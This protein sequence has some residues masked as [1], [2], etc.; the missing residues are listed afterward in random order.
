[1]PDG[2]GLTRNRGFPKKRLEKKER[3]YF[4]DFFIETCR[5]ELTHWI[6][7]LF[8]PLFFFW[9]K[10]PVGWIMVFYAIAENLPLIAVQRYNR[11]RF[12]R[13]LE[14]RL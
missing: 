9:N 11:Q 10:P 14:K 6:I 12:R 8:A 13:I 3:D 1:M 4:K 2:A 7:I 5:A